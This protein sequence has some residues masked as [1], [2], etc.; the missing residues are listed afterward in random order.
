MKALRPVVVI[1]VILG[2]FGVGPELHA[3]QQPDARIAALIAAL[4]TRNWDQAVDQ[5]VA[6]GPQATGQL[7]AT[8]GRR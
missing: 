6:L 5:L 1:V 8:L 7:L 3:R 2:G 4:D